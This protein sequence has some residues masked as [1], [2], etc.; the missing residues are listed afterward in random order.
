[1]KIVVMDG[2]SVL[3]R[4]FYGIR[5]LSNHQ[6][7][8]TN[9]IYGFLST[10]FKLMEEEGPDRLFVCFDRKEKTFRHQQYPAYK[11]QRQGMPDELAMQLP[12]L[13][14]LL[15]AMG[16]VC[17]EL[18]GYEADD[19]LGT[20]SLR[21]AQHGDECVVVTGDKDS[22]QLIGD[23]VT[24]RLV[25]TKMGQ[26]STRLMDEA[27]FREEYG[28]DPIRLIDL[29]SLM[30]DASD[31]I[32]GVKGIGQKTATALI[33]QFGS[34][35]GVYEHLDDSA[36][37]K[38]VRDKLLHDRENAYLSY[39]L[40]TIDRQAPMD[41]DPARL[42]EGKEDQGAV[43][44]LLTRLELKNVIQKLGLSQ[45]DGTNQV[46][47]SEP[48]DDGWQATTPE[49]LP[50]LL[51]GSNGP[52]AVILPAH[53]QI[54]GLRVQGKSYLLEA[55]TDEEAWH[56]ALRCL[57]AKSQR[58]I[59]HEARETYVSLLESGVDP[60]PVGFDCAVAA[61]L[62]SPTDNAYDLPKLALSYLGKEVP[63]AIYRQEEALQSLDQAQAARRALA[64]HLWAMEQLQP[65][66]ENRLEQEQMLSLL[67][68]VELPLIPILASMQKE[69]VYVDRERLQAYGA[70][71]DEGIET[72][73]QE[74]YRLAGEPFQ[75]LSTKQ[76]GE[77]LFVKLQLPVKKKT[78]TGYSTNIDVLESLRHAHPIVP[79]VIEYR[80]LT[81]LKSTYV[82]GLEKVINSKDGRIHSRFH[83][84]VTATGRLS[85]SDPNM[86]NIP[87]RQKL[88]SEL[89][90]MFVAQRP[91]W[92]LI[93][94]DYSQIELRI[95]AHIADDPAMIDAFL[96]GQDIHATTAAQV[97]GVP[98]SEV[99]PQM[100][101]GAKAVNFG[102]VYGISDFSLAEDLG[103]SRKEAGAYI[104]AY[105]RHYSGVHRYM[106]EIRQTAKE[107]G[108]VSSLLGRRRYLP[109]L[110]SKNYNIRS[111]GERAALNTPIQATAADIMKIAMIRVDRRLKQEKC[112][113]KLILQVH[114][115]LIL[116]TPA[117]EIQQVKQLLVE[118]MERAFQ[119]KAPLKADA[120]VGKS[121][122]DAK[123]DA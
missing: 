93:D 32:P 86:Q 88:G 22:L 46:S 65:L 31:N 110:Q 103:V 49:E 120:G 54:C 81:K 95:L 67:R 72:L 94:A 36:I 60:G 102:I 39:Q 63:D 7:L 26:S 62:L 59:W 52:V 14:E 17:Y 10:Y 97:A 25:T 56:H 100:R 30:G 23:G 108:Y 20:I 51:D 29:K 122:Y 57:F 53:L 123:N 15:D 71:L 113:A 12:V 19:L 8:Y 34:L 28:F 111:F 33:Q 116:E 64:L 82:D 41:F 87:V 114:D 3:N 105:L 77:I 78:K 35:D 98:L 13:K 89:R 21:C 118:E 76:L 91:G 66:L 73:T 42:P 45:A 101:S 5:L 106:D 38:G 37:K 11:A 80:Q 6:G 74:I 4:A 75:I 104:A 121:W 107:Q 61:Y 43:Y 115:E 92:S 119:L 70:M 85:S 79:K 16:I 1:M 24:V 27:A 50:V 109:E 68:E 44:Q 9:A 96:S 55:G 83:Q 99:T 47:A 69:G 48:G 117:E 90:R 112:Q 84:T 2:N 58:L 18:A 40:A